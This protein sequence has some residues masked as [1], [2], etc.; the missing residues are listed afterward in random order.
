M[1][2][3]KKSEMK[4]INSERAVFFKLQELCH[5]YFKELNLA[6]D[7]YGNINYLNRDF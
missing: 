1:Q 7:D 2:I 6:V 4:K 3:R 5:I